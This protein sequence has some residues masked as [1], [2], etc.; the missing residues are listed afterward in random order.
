MVPDRVFAEEIKH[1]KQAPALSK[2][3]EPK[4]AVIRKTNVI[5]YKQNRYEVPK[6]T[7]YPGRQACIKAEDESGK[8]TFYDIS[9]GELLAEHTLAC[10]VGK[11]VRLPKHADRYIE[12]KYDDLRQKVIK[13]LAE[14]ETAENY[15]DLLIA[16]YPRYAR[17]QLRIMNKCV[18]QYCKDDLKDAL[19]YCLERGLISAN[20]FRDT[21]EYFR[22]KQPVITAEQI[23]LPEK[24]Q[25]VRPKVRS[26]KSYITTAKGDGV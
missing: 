14:I 26:V 19:S 23:C 24:Y 7:Y 2:P 12:T 1:L 16:K 11:F 10:G 20:D 3:I 9:T 6:G 13:E 18:E 8:V 4:T 5:H 15:I 25:M 22:S 17:D 21:L